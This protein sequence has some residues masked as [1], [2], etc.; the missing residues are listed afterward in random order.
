MPGGSSVW[1]GSAAPVAAGTAREATVVAVAAAVAA[2]AALERDGELL[3]AG[4]AEPTT[5]LEAV[6][7]VETSGAW[8]RS[9]LSSCSPAERRDATS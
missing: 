7:V 2:G 6:A 3:S 5:S 8:C 1:V 4:A 9:A